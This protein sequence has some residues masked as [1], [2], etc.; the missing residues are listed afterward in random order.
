MVKIGLKEEILC[1]FPFYENSIPS[2][3]Q[4]VFFFLYSSTS[5]ANFG[6][7]AP[8]LGEQWPKILPK[9][10]YFMVAESVGQTLKSSNQK[11]LRSRILVVFRNA[12]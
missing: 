5:G 8:D 4:T 1:P 2:I 3:F 7:V 6:N 11:P 9:N 10:G 12:Y